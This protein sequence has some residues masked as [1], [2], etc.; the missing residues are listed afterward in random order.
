[1]KFTVSR[2]SVEKVYG[3]SV[4]ILYSQNQLQVFVMKLFSSGW[5]KKNVFLTNEGVILVKIF[6][7][8]QQLN[9]LKL[10]SKGK[11]TTCDLK[12][13]SILLQRSRHLLAETVNL[14]KGNNKDT[15]T[16]SMSSYLLS[17]FLTLIIFDLLFC[18]LHC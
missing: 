15:R 16:I 5:I 11:I 18:C 2:F 8:C 3:I 14:V 9:T 17:L 4:V 1:M 10:K 6:C 13:F 7:Y 12:Y